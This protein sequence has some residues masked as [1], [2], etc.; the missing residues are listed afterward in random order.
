MESKVGIIY[1]VSHRPSHLCKTLE[2]VKKKSVSESL[3]YFENLS[4][5]D[6]LYKNSRKI[7][8]RFEKCKYIFTRHN[9]TGKPP[10]S[11]LALLNIH[12][13]IQLTSDAVVDK[14]SNNRQRELLLA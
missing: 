1:N 3:L 5:N 7:F 6:T 11:A 8:Q 4:Y 13:D 2:L 14:L 10:L 9:V 12:T